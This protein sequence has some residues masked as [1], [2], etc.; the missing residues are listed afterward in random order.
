M[1]WN[2]HETDASSARSAGRRWGAPFGCATSIT[3]ITALVCLPVWFDGA[4]A[5]DAGLSDNTTRI[6]AVEPS[7]EPRPAIGGGAPDRL[8]IASWDLRDA[9]HAGIVTQP[10]AVKRTWR[11]TFGSERRANASKANGA[12]DIDADVVLLQGVRSAKIAR[13]LFPARDWRLILSRQLLDLTGFD[14]RFGQ[15][16]PD[17]KSITAI[18]VRYS[19]YIRVTGHEHFMSMAAPLRENV[20]PE[21]VSA[22]A[23]PGTTDGIAGPEDAPGGSPVLRTIAQR[24]ETGTAAEP[25]VAGVGV[26][27]LHSKDVIWVVSA[28]FGDDCLPQDESCAR[29]AVLDRWTSEQRA[30]GLMVVRGEKSGTDDVTDPP[31]TAQPAPS[32]PQAKP[33][34][35]KPTG[36]FSWLQGEP[37]RGRESKPAAQNLAAAGNA[38]QAAPAVTV[39]RDC[40]GQSL[41]PDP[42]LDGDI[43]VIAEK[44]CLAVMSVAR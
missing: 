7:A 32:P 29:R 5:Q 28:D 37:E 23:V 41:I 14:N 16:L 31:A 1:G 6:V 11:H 40:S 25:G 20:L 15:P 19:R 8:T 2:W 38:K 17:G 22:D 30:E 4:L 21:P 34:H 12:G 33:A 13:K 39:T 42:Q 43:K 18:A 3:A 35:A 27:I 10:K 44:G 26:R 36:F 9:E 24:D